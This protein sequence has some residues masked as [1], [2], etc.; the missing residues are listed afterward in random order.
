M[1][2]IFIA[3]R[4]GL[5]FVGQIID[6]TTQNCIARTGRY[7]SAETAKSAAASMWRVMQAS[8]AQEAQ[9]VTA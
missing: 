2:V 5:D 8:E 4:H 3:E 9:A 7:A 1:D 6:L